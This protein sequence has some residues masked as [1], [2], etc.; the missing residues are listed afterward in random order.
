MEFMFKT[1]LLASVFNALIDDK[2]GEIF[3]SEN[4]NPIM[5]VTENIKI[6]VMPMRYRKME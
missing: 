3:Y 4:H 6:A 5:I 2:Q 1:D